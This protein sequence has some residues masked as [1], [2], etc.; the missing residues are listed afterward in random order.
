[1]SI[2][3]RPANELASSGVVVVED[4]TVHLAEVAI[5]AVVEKPTEAR[6]GSTSAS[7]RPRRP[8]DSSV[9]LESDRLG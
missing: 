4:S 1:M 7:L 6:T 2:S 5:R 9:G 8:E 3:R